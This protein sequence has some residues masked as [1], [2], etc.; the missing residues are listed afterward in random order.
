MGT[1]RND[2]RLGKLIS[3][4]LTV[5]KVLSWEKQNMLALFFLG[6]SASSGSHLIS[7]ANCFLHYAKSYRPFELFVN[8]N[9]K[10]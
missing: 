7:F 10:L 2:K 8:E 5:R 1:G 4:S 3:V 6:G 9:Y